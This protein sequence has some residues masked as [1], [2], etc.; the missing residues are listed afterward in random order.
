MANFE[1]CGVYQTPQGIGETGGALEVY[2]NSSKFYY[3]LSNLSKILGNYLEKELA[4]SLKANL[5]T[6][7]PEGDETFCPLDSFSKVLL[8][9]SEYFLPDSQVATFT[10]L[11][12]YWAKAELLPRYS[13]KIPENGLDEE[14][15]PY[16][17]YS[18]DNKVVMAMYKLRDAQNAYEMAK[19]NAPADFLNSENTPPEVSR[20]WQ[21]VLKFY[22]YALKLYHDQIFYAAKELTEAA[23][24]EKGFVAKYESIER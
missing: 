18:G 7:Y 19:K 12:A 1:K 21:K 4:D 11:L 10:K 8:T 5:V 15:C 16:L 6:V 13:F 20:E 3:S 17:A 23:M 2:T 14:D 22:D 24:N 9:L